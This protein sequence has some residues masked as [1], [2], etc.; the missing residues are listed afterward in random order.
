M[1]CAVRAGAAIGFIVGAEGLSVNAPRWVGLGDIESALRE[2][3][4]WIL[5]KLREQQERAQRQLQAR[6]DWRDGAAV[7]FLGETVIVV[8]DPRAT[9]RGA[10]QRW[11]SR[12]PA[13][14]RLTLHVGLP[15]TAQAG[16]DPRCRAELA[17][18]PGAARVRGVACDHF[19][20]MRWACVAR[21]SSLS[22]AQTR[23]GSAQRRRLDPPEL[24][25]RA[26]RDADDRLRGHPRA[27]APA[28]DEPQPERFWDVVRSVMARLRARARHA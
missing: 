1:P 24:A 12:C 6:I 28:R 27:R 2:K 25:P 11:R 23:W 17:A 18:A 5:R 16:A 9:G 8:L 26:L 21:G 4:D 22:S 13:V 7:P 10:Q 14:P 19:A 15:H 3:A 20:G